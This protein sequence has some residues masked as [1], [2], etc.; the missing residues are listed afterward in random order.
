MVDVRSIALAM[1][2]TT[3]PIVRTM[4]FMQ[5]G[6]PT[7]WICMSRRRGDVAFTCD[8]GPVLQLCVVVS[9]IP[10]ATL[11]N[12][13]QSSQQASFAKEPPDLPDLQV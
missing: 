6:I 11:I 7:R 8:S 9:V 2:K 3:A 13:S 12:P 4:L 5:T 1:K 10:S